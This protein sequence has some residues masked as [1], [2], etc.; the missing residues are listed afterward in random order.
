MNI[1]SFK[2]GTL[3]AAEIDPDL[4]AELQ[5][6]RAKDKQHAHLRENEI[7]RIDKRVNSK[8]PDL[9][10]LSGWNELVEDDH[11]RP[12]LQNLLDNNFIN[13]T[14]DRKQAQVFIATDPLNGLSQRSKRYA[15]INGCS[16]LS[17]GLL[18]EGK[19]AGLKFKAACKT[20]RM[21]WISDMAKARHPALVNIVCEACKARGC[22]WSII[23]GDRDSFLAKF[24]QQKARNR[25]AVVLGVVASN[26]NKDHHE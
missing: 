18:M 13:I 12:A 25:A 17:L 24:R 23:T 22:K 8:L 16:S 19:G 11:V 7:K 20:Q 9:K 14:E 5:A 10:D 6:Q 2:H 15:A 26:E 4:P 3:L 1:K 21:V